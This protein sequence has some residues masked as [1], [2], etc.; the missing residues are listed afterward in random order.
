MDAYITIARNGG[1]R[2]VGKK[3]EQE[4]NKDIKKERAQH[5]TL[6]SSKIRLLEGTKRVLEKAREVLLPN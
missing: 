2:D 5:T 3:S 1:F 6:W 4:M